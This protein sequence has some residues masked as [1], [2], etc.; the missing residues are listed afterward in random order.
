MMWLK[1]NG[2][3]IDKRYL[4]PMQAYPKDRAG[5]VVIHLWPNGK[6]KSECKFKAGKKK[7]KDQDNKDIEVDG[8]IEAKS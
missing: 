4:D 1:L 2:T 8:D 6:K 7:I 3:D 5:L